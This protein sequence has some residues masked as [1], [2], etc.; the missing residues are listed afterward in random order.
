M[1]FLKNYFSQPLEKYYYINLIPEQK[2]FFQPDHYY[3]YLILFLGLGALS[4]FFYFNF[5]KNKKE[6]KKFDWQWFRK[7]I[8]IF[9]LIIFFI[10]SARWYLIQARWIK[11][12]WIDFS[13]KNLE[14]IHSKAIARI[15]ETKSLPEN[16]HD[17]Y[18]FLKFSQK[19]IPQNS[20]IYLVPAQP[21]FRA[22]AKYWLYP[23]LKI[24]DSSKK[25]DYILSFN[26]ELPE[27]VAGFKRFKEFSAKK[28][29]L[30]KEFL[31]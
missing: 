25:A 23:N 9:F 7:I 12:Y 2:L 21:D 20:I 3:F 28:I 27:Q 8:L 13:Q 11:K 18:D 22:W 1:D 15:M 19:E 10:S 29:I 17:F 31:K 4:A 24:T 14:Q 6:N 30:K 5:I 16:W 26:V